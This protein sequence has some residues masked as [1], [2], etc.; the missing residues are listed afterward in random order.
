MVGYKDSAPPVLAGLGMIA[1]KETF[2]MSGLPHPDE[3]SLPVDTIRR[4]NLTISRSSL[5][6]M[7]FYLQ[8]SGFSVQKMRF[9]LVGLPFS[10][11]EKVFSVAL[12]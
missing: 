6:K 1:I 12:N 8:I 5:L 2:R 7:T 4:Q 9:S 11:N 3:C 10:L